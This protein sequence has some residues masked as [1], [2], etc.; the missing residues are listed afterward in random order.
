MR[1]GCVRLSTLVMVLA[2]ALALPAGVLAA[3]GRPL[4]AFGRQ[5]L[6]FGMLL[7]GVPVTVSRLDAGRAG[8]FEVRGQRLTEIRIDLTLPP[9]LV[10]GSGTQL[11]LQ[12]NAGDGGFSPDAAIAS[13]Q[14]FD[15]RVPL[16]ARLADAGRLYIFLGGTALPGSRQA[17]G[18]YAA[19]ITLTVA[20]TGN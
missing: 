11:P 13:S 6:T 15:P 5:D 17:A 20:Y 9:A 2:L 14:A 12:F 4:S 16:L 10:S 1:V 19:T 18:I 7:A 3:Q 8:Q